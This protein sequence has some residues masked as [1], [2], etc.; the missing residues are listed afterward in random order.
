MTTLDDMVRAFADGQCTHLVLADFMEE[1]GDRRAADVR[2]MKPKVIPAWSRE[3]RTTVMAV[4]F[5]KEITARAT[6]S[7]IDSVVGMEFYQ[8]PPLAPI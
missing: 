4:I 2:S 3:L 8:L 1:I 7:G 5:F 6:S